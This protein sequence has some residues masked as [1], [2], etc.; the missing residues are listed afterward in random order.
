MRFE[1]F[2]RGAGILGG[3]D[4]GSRRVG[5]VLQLFRSF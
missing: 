3:S 2:S 4:E 1:A 5:F